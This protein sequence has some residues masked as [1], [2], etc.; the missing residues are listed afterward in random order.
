[1]S[2]AT[3][4]IRSS[5]DM[6]SYCVKSYLEDLTDADLLI[7]PTEGANHMAWQLGHLITAE[8]S[9]INMVCPGSMPDLPAGFA[10]HYTKET[11]G[12]DDASKFHT[13]DVYLKLMDEQRAG[14][15]AALEKLSDEALDMDAPEAVRDYAPTVA[16]TFA[17][18]SAHWMMHSGQ[19]VIVRRQLGRKPLF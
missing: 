13:K 16:A 10:E 7:R 12:L 6:A 14:T 4:V 2:T 3:N 11:A 19:W 1:M 5:L 18:Q 9:L 8:H 17:L 15:L